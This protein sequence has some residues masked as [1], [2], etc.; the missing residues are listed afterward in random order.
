M[1]TPTQRRTSSSRK[2]RASHAALSP[3][4]TTTC[5]KCK[6][7]KLP[8]HACSFCGYHHKTTLPKKVR[9]K[10]SVKPGKDR[11]KKDR[12][13]KEAKKQEKQV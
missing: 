1:A 2:R 7:P 9:V 8:H 6:K 12:E 3:I 13:K 4:R 10:K 11:E 5:P